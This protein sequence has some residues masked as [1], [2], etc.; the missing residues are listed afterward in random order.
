MTGKMEKHDTYK[1]YVNLGV[2]VHWL[3]QLNTHYTLI[4]TLPEVV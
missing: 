2:Q 4:Y 3:Q 1:L